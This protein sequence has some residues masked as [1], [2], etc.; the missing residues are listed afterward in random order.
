MKG[1]VK[2]MLALDHIIISAHD[3]EKSARKFAKKHS[4]Q[5]TKGGE[6]PDW[7]TYNYLAYFQNNTYIEWI[8]INDIKIAT[9]SK[10]PLIEQVV[11][12]L[13]NNIERP[14]QYALR[15]KEMDLYI[16]QMDAIKFAYTGPFSGSRGR[17]DGSVLEWRML[18]P[19]CPTT[20]PLPFLIE[21][22]DTP[23]APTDPEL[24]NQQAITSIT[25][26][27]KNVEAFKTAFHLPT[28]SGSELIKLQ[29]SNIHLFLGNQLTFTIH[30]N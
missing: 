28:R 12:A 7:G 3:P 26:E 21:W 24:T 4:I 1:V 20:H 10:N 15:T 23:N 30:E 19:I 6:H 2:R 18:F 17:P 27:R 8:G 22:G 11:E 5:I 14:I 13:T 16:E 29:N 25:D 9:E